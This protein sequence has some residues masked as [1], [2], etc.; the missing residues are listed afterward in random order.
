MARRH[1]GGVDALAVADVQHRALRQRARDLVRARQHRV[2]ALRQPAR[3]QRLVEAEVR[4]PG[5]VDDQRHAGGV[6]HLGAAA[7]VGRHPVVGRRDDERRARL[8]RGAPAR[9]AA[10]PASTPCAMP[11][12]ASYSGATKA[13]TPPRE[14]EPVDERGVRVAL[15]DDVRAERRERQAQR[16]VALR[17]AVG[18]EPRARGAVGLGGEALGP[19]VGR[20]RRP[21]VDAVDVLRDVEPQR[22]VAEAEAQAG[23]GALAALVAGDVEAPGTAGPVAD[24]GVEVGR[25]RLLA[26][27]W[28]AVAQ[29]LGADE[30]VEV[31]VEH[32][33]GVAHLEVRAVVLDHRVRVQDVGADLRAEVDVLRLAPL[34][35]DLLAALALLALEQLGAQHLHRRVLVGR[36]R[37]LVLALH[38]DPAR[39]VRDAHGRVGLVDVL[40]AGARGAVGVDLQVVVV[41]LDV[42]RRPRPPARPR[43]RRT[44]SGGGGRRRRATGAR[45]GARPSRR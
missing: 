8:G 11:S 28:P 24:H 41:D 21:E 2:G 42:A 3:R 35:G 32:A 4:A 44:T 23:V 30:A 45:A 25:G 18:Q 7:D 19:L 6:G 5:L 29:Q 15:G 36:L 33:L 17:R 40:A 31:A 43:R 27:A 37:A 12:S 13:G 10:R 38:D 9:R 34:G 26:H 39:A 1:G 16:V 22:A 14:H 20:R